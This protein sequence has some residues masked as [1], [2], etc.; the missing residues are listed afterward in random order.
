MTA[1]SPAAITSFE[2]IETHVLAAALDAFE[3]AEDRNDYPAMEDYALDTI[4]ASA[5]LND[6][7]GAR[8]VAAFAPLDLAAMS[9]LDLAQ[10]DRLD[11]L[12]GFA[13]AMQ[14]VARDIL[15]V[16]TRNELKRVLAEGESALTERSAHRGPEN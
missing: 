7:E 16:L 6:P 14:E 8:K 15:H 13:A 5:L 4:D 3:F 11:P 2:D 9:W 1:K 10:Q 12:E